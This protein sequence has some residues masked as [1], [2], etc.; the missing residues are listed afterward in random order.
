MKLK[1][2]EA[3][4]SNKIP[5]TDGFKQRSKQAPREKIEKRQSINFKCE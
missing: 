2:K 5:D 1:V 3:H 4:P